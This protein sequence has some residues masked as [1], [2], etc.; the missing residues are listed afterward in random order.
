MDKN[1]GIYHQNITAAINDWFS[2]NPDKKNIDL[3]KHFNVSEMTASRW[4]KGINI[5]DVELLPELAKFL[6][7]SLYELFG[8]KDPSILSDEEK[9]L[10]SNYREKSSMQI[11]VKKLLSIE[12]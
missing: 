6:G 4:H 2:K 3:A 10:I 7:I 1:T 9:N 12:N 8:I 11:A 5:P